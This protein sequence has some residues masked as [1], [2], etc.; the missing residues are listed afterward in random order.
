MLITVGMMY[1]TVILI[2]ILATANHFV[3]DAVAGFIVAVAGWH[4]NG[5][6][7]NL[8]PLEDWLLNLVHV[9]KPDREEARDGTMSPIAQDGKIGPEEEWWRRA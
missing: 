4:I 6:L 1:P 7:V 9:H 8:L 3:L 2:A 5:V